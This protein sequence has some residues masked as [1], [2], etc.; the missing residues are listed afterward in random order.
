[1][2]LDVK[3]LIKKFVEKQNTP[4]FID[5][6]VQTFSVPTTWS[7]PSGAKDYDRLFYFFPTW[8]T[9]NTSAYKNMMVLV[10]AGQSSISF[11]NWLTNAGGVGSNFTMQASVIEI[12][13]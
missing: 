2:K 12:G 3:E 4:M 11:P 7:I 8:A 9:I 6:G 10:P 5:L 13:R 1:M